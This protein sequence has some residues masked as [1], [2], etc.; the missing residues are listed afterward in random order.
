MNWDKTIEHLRLPTGEYVPSSHLGV[1]SYLRKRQL[2]FLKVPLLTILTARYSK[3]L[4][5]LAVYERYEED[6]WRKVHVKWSISPMIRSLSKQ[7]TERLATLLSLLPNYFS[8]QWLSTVKNSGY[9]W[10]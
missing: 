6:T 3:K 9:Q 8:D 4:V 7:Q 1:L 10:K 2:F 5:L